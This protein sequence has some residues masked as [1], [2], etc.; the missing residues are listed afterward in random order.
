[1]F[2]SLEYEAALES[3]GNDYFD[4]VAAAEFPCHLLRFRNNQLLPLLGLNPDDVT[5]G[6]F[7]QAFGKF[8][9][10][11]PFLALRYHGYQF[12]EYNSR[13]GDGRG[14]LYGQ[15]RG[16]DG[17]LYDFGTKG[18]GTTPYS[19]NADGR[20]TL[21]GGV[22]EVLA[23]EALHSLGVRT[24]RCLSLIETGE[25][26]WRGDEPSPTRS[27][28]M[29]RFSRSHIRF[30]TFERL[31]Y[32]KRRDLIEK[33]L[34][35][36]IQYYY[37][38]LICEQLCSSAS[39]RALDAPDFPQLQDKIPI[40]V[41]FYAE[42]VQRVAELVAQWMAAGFCHAVLNTDNM[43]ITGESFDYGPYAF[44]PTYNPNFTAAYFDYYGR[45]CYGNQPSICRL[46]LEMLQQ[47]LKMVIPME[48]MEAGLA[49]FD[50]YYYLTYRKIM[51]SKL[52]FVEISESL[53]NELL[54]LTINFLAETQVGY[55]AFFTELT[56]QFEPIW[57]D[58]PSKIFSNTSFLPST[59]QDLLLGN[60]REL[61]HHILQ[62]LSRDELAQ[63]SHRLRDKNP[64]TA[65]L[66]PIIE[67]VW[68]EIDRNDTWEP[69]DNLVKKLQD[70]E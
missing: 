28:V 8:V 67:E 30:G 32:F 13:L 5:D 64:Q 60:W 22:R 16:I 43:S 41:Q 56:K 21:K 7:I 18:T 40:Y 37:P 63:V 61:Y 15:V 3:L 52:G 58:D 33:L 12:G 23:A 68:G 24:S 14:F 51:L 42:L 4:E 29:I 66:R 50:E 34:D 27:S 36:V 2:L 25:Q 47:P 35:H 59:E 10:I 39:Y 45:Y 20:L 9:G 38:H 46:N 55:H 1:M 26:L 54:N 57:R 49:R 70:K 62:D 48:D 65:L 44:I 53:G 11:R 19:R 69:F 17:T 6:D 31:Y